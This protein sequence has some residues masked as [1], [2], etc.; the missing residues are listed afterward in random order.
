[1]L[2]ELR[3]ACQ[4]WKSAGAIRRQ[5]NR[6]VTSNLEGDLALGE[7]GATASSIGEER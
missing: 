2:Q 5:A 7:P 4:R 3:A 6:G 1:M